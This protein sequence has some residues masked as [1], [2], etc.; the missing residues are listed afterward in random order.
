[1][2]SNL[3]RRRSAHRNLHKVTFAT[4]SDS[5]DN[6]TE[7]DRE[8]LKRVEDFKRFQIAQREKRQRA[9]IIELSYFKCKEDRDS[10]DR[11]LAM[12]DYYAR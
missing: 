4:D 2:D 3:S 6:L 12:Q 1:M 8:M 10:Y 7:E 11:E 9:D 5:E